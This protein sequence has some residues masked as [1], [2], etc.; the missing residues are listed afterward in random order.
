MTRSAHTYRFVAT[1]LACVTTGCANTRP[2]DHQHIYDRQT[3]RI[4]SANLFKPHDDANNHEWFDLAPLIVHDTEIADT[5]NQLVKI[6]LAPD[7]T[8]AHDINTPTVYVH[9][10]T[11]ELNRQTFRQITCV[12]FY[13]TNAPTHLTARAIRTTLDPDG[14]PVFWEFLNPDDTAHLIFVAQ[15]IESAAQTANLPILKNRRHRVEPSITRHP[16]TIV[17][18][19]LADGPIPMGPWVYLDRNHQPIT[20]LCRCMPSQLDRVIADAYYHLRP[21]TDLTTLVLD[22]PLPLIHELDQP[23]AI[24]H[25]RLPKPTH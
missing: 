5:R 22:K 15:S 6:E 20:L 24:H 4:P 10:S 3:T 1:L 13:T 7:G 11:T 14:F 19:I 23:S 9:E 18:R 2:I 16:N 21:V 17:P 25:L 12:W 8:I